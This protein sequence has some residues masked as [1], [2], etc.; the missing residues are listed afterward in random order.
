VLLLGIGDLL[1]EFCVPKMISISILLRGGHDKEPPAFIPVLNEGVE[2]SFIPPL[3][4]LPV[5]DS[6]SFT[7]RLP[8]RKNAGCQMIF[9]TVQGDG[10]VRVTQLAKVLGDVVSQFL[11]INIAWSG[12]H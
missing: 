3:F 9:Q 7:L 4:N 6:Y 2:D 5:V 8:R 10:R 12:G 11:W 1:P